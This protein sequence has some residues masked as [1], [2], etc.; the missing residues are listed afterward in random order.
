[1][2]I[3]LWTDQLRYRGDKDTRLERKYDGPC[4]VLKKMGK[5]SYKIDISAWMKI[6]PVIHV[7]NLKQYHKDLVDP[8]R[9]NPLEE[10][11]KPTSRVAENL[12]KSWQKE[13]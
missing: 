8:V 2:L 12:K 4:S 11:S 1:M 9:N 7:S 5:V 3:K 13:K 6:R 10:L